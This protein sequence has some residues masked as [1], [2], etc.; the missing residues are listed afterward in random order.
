MPLA[1]IGDLEVYIELFDVTL[2]IFG[3][4]R[5]AGVVRQ[6]DRIASA[7]TAGVVP[8]RNSIHENDRILT[9]KFSYTPGRV[10]SKPAPADDD[11]V[12]LDPA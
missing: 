1:Q 2:F 6:I 11:P 5:V 4:I 7:T 9:V 10:S 3:E 8:N 12:R